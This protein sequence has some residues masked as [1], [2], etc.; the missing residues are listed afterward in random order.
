MFELASNI[1]GSSK[2]HDQERIGESH[3]GLA[4][5]SP[6]TNWNRPGLSLMKRASQNSPGPMAVQPTNHSS[7]RPTAM[8]SISDDQSQSAT[9]PDPRTNAIRVAEAKITRRRSLRMQRKA[10]KAEWAVSDIEPRDQTRLGTLLAERLQKLAEE[11]RGAAA[12]AGPGRERD[13]LTKKADKA[14]AVA[15]AANRLKE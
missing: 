6:E 12:D 3:L 4:G 1:F 2:V 13:I 8:A 7:I 9:R 11:A 10:Q 15:Q 5:V 14:E